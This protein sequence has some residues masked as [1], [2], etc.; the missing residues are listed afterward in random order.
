[1]E[2]NQNLLTKFIS[3]LEE[4]EQ[5]CWFQ[6]DAAIANTENTTSLLKEFSG[7]CTVR[8]D[9]WPL[10]CSDLQTSFCEYF[11]KKEFI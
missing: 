6:Y 3:L 4:N 8:H 2:W 10:Q 5:D 1:V 9:L 7:D 11:S